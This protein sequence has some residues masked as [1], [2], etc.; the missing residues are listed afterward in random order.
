[1]LGKELLVPGM[2]E[3]PSDGGNVTSFAECERLESE[4]AEFQSFS[5]FKWKTIKAQT[6]D[7]HQMEAFGLCSTSCEEEDDNN[8]NCRENRFLRARFPWR[9]RLFFWLKSE[10]N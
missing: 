10:H 5:E 2:S 3:L 8:I 1:M 4:R 6:L 9:I 7:W